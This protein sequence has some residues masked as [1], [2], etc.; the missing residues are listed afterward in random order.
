MGNTAPNTYPNYHHQAGLLIE[1]KP[2]HHYST[3]IDETSPTVDGAHYL[4]CYDAGDK[5]PAGSTPGEAFIAQAATYGTGSGSFYEW[6]TASVRGPSWVTAE[7]M[8]LPR[9][10]K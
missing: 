3:T 8:S 2:R 10:E 1:A 9:P 5:P 6:L 7:L 4:A